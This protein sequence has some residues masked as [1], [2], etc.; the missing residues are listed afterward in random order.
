MTYYSNNYSCLVCHTKGFSQ[1]VHHLPDRWCLGTVDY[2]DNSSINVSVLQLLLK[3]NSFH[4][5]SLESAE[6]LEAKL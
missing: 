6:I 1:L 2:L 4:S 5:C 3:A